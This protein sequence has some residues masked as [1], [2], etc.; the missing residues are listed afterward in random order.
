V[1]LIK[2][3]LQNRAQFSEVD[4]INELVR[5][6]FQAGA[7]D[8]HLQ[9][10]QQGVVLRLRINGVLQ[11]VAT[12]THEEYIVYLMKIKYISGVKI[13][14]AKTPQD[15]RFDFWVRTDGDL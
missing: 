9:S 5:L 7:S 1:D 14:I 11:N 4:L 3:T 2:E 15:G 12:L 13:N 8:M 6:S 10:E